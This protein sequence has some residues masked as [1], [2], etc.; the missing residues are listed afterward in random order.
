MVILSEAIES[1]LYT[2]LD[3]TNSSFGRVQLRGHLNSEV[4]RRLARYEEIIDYE[5]IQSR[6]NIDEK[7]GFSKFEFKNGKIYLDFEE[8]PVSVL[9]SFARTSGFKKMVKFGN[10]LHFN[11]EYFGVENILDLSK[12]SY[13]PIFLN[14]FEYLIPNEYYT[15]TFAYAGEDGSWSESRSLRFFVGESEL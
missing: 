13:D 15:I 2:F 4:Q 12:W 1:P 10:I 6:A 5:K 8:K 3:A 11:R 9:V 7:L 14:Y